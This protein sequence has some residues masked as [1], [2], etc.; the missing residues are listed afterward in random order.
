MELVKAIALLGAGAMVTE[1]VHWLLGKRAFRAARKAQEIANINAK[2]YGGLPINHL[3]S[4]RQQIRRTT[5]I[6]Y[7][8]MS[9]AADPDLT[10]S[11]A[12]SGEPTPSE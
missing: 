10:P 1:I 2:K 5:G 3:R 9:P 6:D 12:G 7:G 8:A 4:A 11:T